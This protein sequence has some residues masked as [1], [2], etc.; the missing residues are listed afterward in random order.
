M[1]NEEIKQ[2]VEDYF[3]EMFAKDTDYLDHITDSWIYDAEEWFLNRIEKEGIKI[4]TND[5][6]YEYTKETEELVGI[7]WGF[8]LKKKEEL[9]DEKYGARDAMYTLNWLIYDVKQLQCKFEF[10]KKHF[11]TFPTY[12]NVVSTDFANLLEHLQLLSDI[13]NGK[14]ESLKEK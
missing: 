6:D 3:T 2:A 13:E 4:F 8:A 7:F 11:K 12:D 5:T 9:Y 10:A 1:T 14:I